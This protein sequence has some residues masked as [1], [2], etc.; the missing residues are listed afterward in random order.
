M[1]VR[2]GR[3]VGVRT[4]AR[5]STPRGSNVRC[6]TG[7]KFFTNPSAGILFVDFLIIKIV[8]VFTRAHWTCCAHWNYCLSAGAVGGVELGRFG[9]IGSRRFDYAHL[10]S[11]RNWNRS[12]RRDRVQPH[13]RKNILAAVSN[14]LFDKRHAGFIN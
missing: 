4:V 7:Q 5:P 11:P 12:H 1:L 6:E 10:G 14:S 8:E 13:L 2:L 9:G 3:R